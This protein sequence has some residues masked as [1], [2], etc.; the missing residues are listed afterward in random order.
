[1]RVTN[2]LQRLC[3]RLPEHS[4]SEVPSLGIPFQ[5]LKGQLGEQPLACLPWVGQQVCRMKTYRGG[6]EVELT[7]TDVLYA[8]LDVG[9]RRPGQ[10]HALGDLLLR[11]PGLTASCPQ[12]ASELGVQIIHLIIMTEVDL[13]VNFPDRQH[14]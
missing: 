7:K 11:Q 14:S 4:D 12:L 8:A 2:S 3:L 13:D 1:M 9:D 6:K 5:L 10:P